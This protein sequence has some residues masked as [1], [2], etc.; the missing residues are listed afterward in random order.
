MNGIEKVFNYQ[1]FL[2]VVILTGMSHRCG[3]VGVPS[4]NPLFGIE[5]FEKHPSI[6]STPENFFEVH[7]G[8]T[9][10]GTLSEIGKDYWYFGFDCAH[11]GDNPISQNL[12]FC[13]NECKK[14]AEQFSQIK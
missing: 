9:Y 1:G 3:Y 5:Y 6:N 10:S 14:L 12:A 2:C 8:I 13:V 11:A 7:G 4:E